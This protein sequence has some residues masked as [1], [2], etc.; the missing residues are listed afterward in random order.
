MGG[1]IADG[2]WNTGEELVRK[3][4]FA[5]G[6]RGSVCFLQKACSFLFL[7]NCSNSLLFF[8]AA[9]EWNQQKGVCCFMQLSAHKRRGQPTS[10]SNHGGSP[11][12]SQTSGASWMDRGCELAASLHRQA[13]QCLTTGR[14]LEVSLVE[15]L[16]VQQTL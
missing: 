13:S 15:P 6:R 10:A 11:W 14:A 9:R 4:S 2:F 12:H 3:G 1:A 5:W 7:S 16:R 8:S